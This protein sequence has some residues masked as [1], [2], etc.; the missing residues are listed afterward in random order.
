MSS[1]PSLQGL[2]SEFDF[3]HEFKSSQVDCAS[4][5]GCSDEISQYQLAQ[6]FPNSIDRDQVEHALA[7]IY[8]IYKNGDK[9]SLECTARHF[10]YYWIGDKLSNSNGGSGTF[11]AAMSVICRRIKDNYKPG[12]CELPCDDSG[13]VD[14]DIFNSRKKLFDFWYDGNIVQTLLEISGSEGTKICAKYIGEID[15][16]YE[17]VQTH[18][19]TNGSDKYCTEFWNKNRNKINQAL[20]G[21][22]HGLQAAQKRTTEAAKATS[23]AVE[24]AVRNATTTSS[25]SSILGTLAATTVPF[26][27][28]KYKLLPS[29]FGNNSNGRSRKKRSTARNRDTLTE[30]SSTF[31]S[32]DTS[33]IGPTDLAEN[34]TVRSGVYTTPSTRQSTGRTNNAPGRPN[35]GYQNL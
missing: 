16:A 26:F 10:F 15:E 25:I 24:E 8:N 18:C 33:T 27:L 14:R 29:W 23:A 2:P 20:Q 35:I 3:Y 30:D 1:V 11:R 5:N 22:N 7:H 19:G 13:H 34:S 21:V 28:Y 4:G 17:A 12:G 9:K 32:T 31:D 6:K